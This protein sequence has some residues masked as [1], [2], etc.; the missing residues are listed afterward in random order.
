MKSSSYII[1]FFREDIDREQ[2]LYID[3]KESANR[4]NNPSDDEIID[5]F[6]NEQYGL[7]EGEFEVT[8]MT[9]GQRVE[10]GDDYKVQ[11]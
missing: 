7:V 9:I 4:P 3:I 8:E 11:T 1:K 5:D 10:I 2:T 6:M